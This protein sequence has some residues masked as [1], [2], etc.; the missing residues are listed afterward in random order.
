[1]LVFSG[2]ANGDVAPI[3]VLKG[4]RTQIKY[5]NGVFVDTKNDEV[6]VANF[7]NHRATVYKR[8]ASGD[9]PPLRVIRSAPADMPA[10]LLAN[11]RITFD[12]KR[13]EILAANCV[14]HPQIAAFATLADGNA[15]PTRQIAGQLTQLGRTMHQI[16]H[17]P[18]HDEIV[19]PNAFSHAILTFRGGAN[20]EVA[21]VRV[22]QGPLTGFVMPDRVTVDPINNELFVP[23]RTGFVHVFP[24]DAVGNVAPIRKLGPLK[25][26]SEV[27]VDPT[28]NLLI[29][30]GR[31]LLQVF[32]RTDNGAVA[33]KTLI[34]GGPKSGTT[35][36]GQ[37]TGAFIPSTRLYLAPTRK[38]GLA[39]GGETS[40]FQSPEDAGSFIAAWSVDDSGDAPPRWTIAHDILLE[41]RGVALDPKNKNVMVVDKGLNAILTYHFP[42]VFE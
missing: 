4:P 11:A 27:W 35:G 19:T 36:P 1:V 3:R 24:R 17:D 30:T 13:G 25:A 2:S 39:D 20:G 38:Y 6:W 29:V 8:G 12:T 33:P 26:A 16:V 14:A 21:P 15:A 40:N 41:V 9:T 18:V 34:T 31:G 22:L 10:P 37:G 7:G 42:E 5:P 23:I 32:N 28:T